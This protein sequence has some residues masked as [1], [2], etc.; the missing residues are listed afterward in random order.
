[1]AD[2]VTI[3]ITLGEAKLMQTLAIWERE[4]LSKPQSAHQCPTLETLLTTLALAM[5]EGE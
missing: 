4:R 5:T 2:S 3:T 1:M